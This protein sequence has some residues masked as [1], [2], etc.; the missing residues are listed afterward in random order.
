MGRVDSDNDPTYRVCRQT[1][2]VV[3]ADAGTHTA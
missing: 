3:P 1:N 2:G